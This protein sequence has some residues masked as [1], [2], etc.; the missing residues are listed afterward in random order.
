M[1]PE[2][3]CVSLPLAKQLKELNVPQ[4]S[5]FYWAQPKLD[6]PDPS[7]DCHPVITYGKQGRIANVTFTSLGSAFTCAE[8]GEMLP[9]FLLDK[10]GV[11]RYLIINHG[12]SPISSGLP[13]FVSYDCVKKEPDYA[14]GTEDK[15]LTN[16]CGKMLLYLLQNNLITFK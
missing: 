8:I 5:L 13:W 6:I 7:T 2:N 14:I 1:P 10:N 3:Q 9:K 15:N 12:D 16:A 11:A 4:T